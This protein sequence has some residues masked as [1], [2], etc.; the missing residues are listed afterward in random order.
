MSV[1]VWLEMQQYIQRYAVMINT[2]GNP[3]KVPCGLNTST[4]L[5]KRALYSYLLV[6]FMLQHLP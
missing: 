2:N 1:Y 5:L 3:G 4:L 6:R